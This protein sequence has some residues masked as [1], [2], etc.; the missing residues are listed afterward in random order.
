MFSSDKPLIHP[1]QDELDYSP[2]AEIMAKTIVNMSPPDGLVI[3]L[4]GP[5]GAGKTTVLNFVVHYLKQYDLASQPIIV[6]FNPW[7]FSDSENLVRLLINQIRVALGEKDFTELKKKLADFAEVMSSIPSIPGFGLGGVGKF[8]ADKARNQPDIV[9]LKESIGK[10][11]EKT[12][13]KILIIIDDIDRLPAEET[14]EIFRI[15]KAVAGFP[16]TIYLL[17]FDDSVVI[18]ALEQGFVTSG[19]DYLE[20]IVQV[21]FV[22]PKPEKTSLRRLLFSKLESVLIDTPEELF[23]KTY[24]TNTYFEGIDHFILTPRD[25]TRLINALRATYPALVGEVNPVDYI[26]VETIRVFSPKFYEIIQA[27]GDQLTGVHSTWGRN[28]QEIAGEKAMYEQWLEVVSNQDRGGLK[29]LMSRLFPK[30]AG[31]YGGPNYAP[32]YI[33]IWQKQLRVSSPDHFSVYFRFSISPDSVSTA[34]LKV[35]LNK[36]S[37]Q[38]EFGEALIAYSNQ[39]RRDGR[40][41]LRVVLDRLEAY[42]QDLPIDKIPAVVKS[43]FNIGDQLLKKEDEQRGLFEIDNEMQMMR[44]IY[45][46]LSRL[47]Q[48]QRYL[49]LKDAVTKGNAIGFIESYV[50]TLGQEHGKF[51][52]EIRKSESEREV[53]NE[54]LDKLE[55]IALKKIR[56][57]AKQGTLFDSPNLISIL[58]RWKAWSGSENEVKKWV[59]KITATDKNLAKFIYY[60]GKVTRSQTFGDIAVKQKYRLDSEWIRPFADPDLIYPRVQNILTQAD[61]P[62]DYKKAAE[63]FCKEYEMRQRGENPDARY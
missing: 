37:S 56:K 23:D 46:L 43:F 40:T 4:N 32:D 44:I 57:T 22:L 12:K 14:R 7:W 10:L 55:S 30:F 18:D 17:S 13:K 45:Q 5:W 1:D 27:N 2:F 53:N 16:S 3:A 25:V 52:V 21:P 29:K 41:R 11:L 61:I 50:A 6:Y 34:E 31:A 26:A 24:W 48:E 58:F 8:F 62:D 38:E 9:S 20:K 49:I 28:T 51:G 47:S 39:H 36:A 54:Q 42:T 35:L 15:I 63:Q 19:K 33:R 59:I 60:F